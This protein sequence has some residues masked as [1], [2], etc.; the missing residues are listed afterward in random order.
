MRDQMNQSN[1][2]DRVVIVS[3]PL[4][5]IDNSY[6]NIDSPSDEINNLCFHKS[7]R[8]HGNPEDK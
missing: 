7:E 8:Y 3:H 1:E 5:I 2:D 6:Q 4:K